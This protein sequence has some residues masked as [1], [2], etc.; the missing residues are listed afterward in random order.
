MGG[1][2]GWEGLVALADRTFELTLASGNAH[3][4]TSSG[5]CALID[6]ASYLFQRQVLWAQR[7]RIPLC[8]SAGDRGRL[9]YTRALDDNLFEPLSPEAAAEYSSGDGDELGRNIG[10][11]GKMQALHSSSALGCNLFHYC[12]RVDPGAILHACGLPTRGVEGL[13]CEGR[14]PISEQFRY[15]PNLDVLV[16]YV[17]DSAVAAIECKFCEP[18]STRPKAPLSEKYFEKALDGLWDGSPALRA[19]AGRC[20]DPHAADFSH[21]DAPQLLKHVLGLRRRAGSHGR[22]LYL[23]YDVPGREG[24]THLDEIARFTEATTHDGVRFSSM[25]YQSVL[26][27]L[28]SQRSAHGA[29]VDY[30]A[31]RYL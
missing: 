5:R 20:C 15:A 23:Y 25:S 27:R 4:Q 31:E 12:R 24:A 14:L 1:P 6:A 30:M 3:L 18:F 29:W 28:A 19:L 2:K 8:G 21:L 10:R 26:L 9:A 16:T 7:K 17:G 11:P 13:V 22:L